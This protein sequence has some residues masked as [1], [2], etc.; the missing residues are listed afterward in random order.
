LD[1]AWTRV[2]STPLPLR[3][4]LANKLNMAKTDAEAK[5]L[6]SEA[7]GGIAD[8]S[9]LLANL[10]LGTTALTTPRG[11]KQSEISANATMGRS[12][13]TRRCSAGGCEGSEAPVAVVAKRV[14]D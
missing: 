9:P 13:D 11:I 5:N 2:R 6:G 7:G 14:H 3:L 1:W 10:G 4:T 8:T 12:E